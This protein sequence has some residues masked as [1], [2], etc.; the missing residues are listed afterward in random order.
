VT[1]ASQEED[2]VSDPTLGDPDLT[3]DQGSGLQL[4][5]PDRSL[6]WSPRSMQ[7]TWGDQAQQG[8][9]GEGRALEAREGQPPSFIELAA[10]RG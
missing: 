5:R 10:I 7:A 6:P 3:W 2:E 4:K 1:D 8:H 9:P